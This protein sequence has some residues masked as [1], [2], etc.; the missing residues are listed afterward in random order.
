MA[1]NGNV[2]Q[3]TEHSQ[4][5]VLWTCTLHVR[6]GHFSTHYSMDK[7]SECD[8]AKQNKPVTERQTL[9]QSMYMKTLKQADPRQR[10][11]G[12]AGCWEEEEGM[13]FRET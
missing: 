3:T 1:G 4:D 7:T 6:W 13:L 9:Q 10:V 11:N 8:D 12:S 5:I 2:I